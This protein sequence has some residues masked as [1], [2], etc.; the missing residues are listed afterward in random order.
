M[1][2]TP[3]SSLPLL[4]PGWKSAFD[5]ASGKVYYYRREDSKTQ[6]EFPV[7]DALAPTST[8]VQ[9][10]DLQKIIVEAARQ[11]AEKQA[12]QKAEEEKKRAEEERIEKEAAEAKAKERAERKLQRDEKRRLSEGHVEPPKDGKTKLEK[13]F[14]VQVLPKF[15]RGV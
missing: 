13:Q 6:W 8:S 15:E 5:N 9:K 3:S 12:A 2:S 1:S 7:E 11:Q 14:S 4:P 10:S